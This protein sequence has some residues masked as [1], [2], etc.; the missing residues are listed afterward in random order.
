M[1]SKDI[2]GLFVRVGGRSIHGSTD[3]ALA[4]EPSGE[5]WPQRGAPWSTDLQEQVPIFTDSATVTALTDWLPIVGLA[6]A[7][8]AC[9]KGDD[10]RRKEQRASM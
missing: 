10:R 5:Q 1:G 7:A 6:F 4:M 3:E 9:C 8:S 2:V